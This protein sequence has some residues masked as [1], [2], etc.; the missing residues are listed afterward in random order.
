LKKEKEV[1]L[2]F[3]DS[4]HL[5]FSPIDILVT[6]IGMV[7]IYIFALRRR[8]FYWTEDYHKYYIPSLTIKFAF[9]LINALFYILIYDGGGDSIGFWRSGVKLTNLLFHNPAG[10]VQELLNWNTNGSMYTNFNL[11]T[12]YP[13]S[14]I[15]IEKESF[16]VSKISSLFSF[17]CFNSYLLTSLAFATISTHASWRLFMVARSYQLHSDWQLALA[18]F[19]VPSVS[20][21]CGGISKDTIVFVSLCYFLY[22]LYKIFNE[23]SSP[24]WKYWIYIGICLYFVYHVRSFMLLAFLVPFTYAITSRLV[25]KYRL[26]ALPKLSIRLFFGAVIFLS[27]VYFFQT[28]TAKSYLQ[29]A[30]I[31]NQDMRTN[32]TYGQNRYALEVDEYSFTGILKAMPFS[33]FT[34]IYRPFIW[35]ALDFSLFINGL[36]SLLLVFLTLRFTLSANIKERIA[37]IRYNELLTFS[38]FFIVIL[39]FFAGFTSILFGVLVRFKAPILPFMVLLLTSYYQTEKKSEEITSSS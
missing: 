39:A 1:Q 22:Y 6:F 4:N 34:G 14:R 23:K 28:N 26:H 37:T 25:A 15:Y 10:Y 31:I 38:F 29:E 35:E 19:F 16:F 2:N 8:I 18:I 13:D 20:F 30:A 5:F 17:F 12:G 3:F 24:S 7:V 9:V 27:F 33:I 36:E 11:L 21:W 32:L